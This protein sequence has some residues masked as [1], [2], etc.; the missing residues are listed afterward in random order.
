MT[1]QPAETWQCIV[2]ARKIVR[3][4]RPSQKS[5]RRPLPSEYPRRVAVLPNSPPAAFRLAEPTKLLTRIRLRR[6]VVGAPRGEAPKALR[7]EF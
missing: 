7:G 4:S 1:L 3:D 2:T 6:S 5:V